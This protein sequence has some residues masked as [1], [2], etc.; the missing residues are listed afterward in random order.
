MNQNAKETHAI[1]RENVGMKFM[2]RKS[3]TTNTSKETQI[4]VSKAESPVVVKVHEQIAIRFL[5]I[6]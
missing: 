3:S 4:T 1:V 5:K 2:D 6:S